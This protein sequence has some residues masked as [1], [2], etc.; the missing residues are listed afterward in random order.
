LGRS[1]LESRYTCFS[2]QTCWSL[3]KRKGKYIH[4]CIVNSK[5]RS[6]PRVLDKYSALSN[7]EDEMMWLND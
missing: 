4:I 2:S 5:Q 6:L 1:S 7:H 3:Q